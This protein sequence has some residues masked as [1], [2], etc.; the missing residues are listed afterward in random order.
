MKHIR[1]NHKIRLELINSSMA[2]I[3]FQTIDRDREYLK[4][5]ASVCTI[6]RQN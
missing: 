5:M 2:E 4:K 1:V 6:H 3:V